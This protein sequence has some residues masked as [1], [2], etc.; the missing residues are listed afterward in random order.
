VN[1]SV[2]AARSWRSLSHETLFA[3]FGQRAAQFTRLFVAR[4]LA[5]GR[6]VA[7]DPLVELAQKS[8]ALG[9]AG[10]SPGELAAELEE[11]R[12]GVLQLP[13]V[14]QESSKRIPRVLNCPY[15]KSRVRILL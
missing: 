10:A 11:H 4:A 13:P 8:V 1:L 12:R 6:R 9:A 7:H 3:H 15:F 5:A 2:R 14:V